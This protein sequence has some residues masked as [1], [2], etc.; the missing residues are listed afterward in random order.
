[1]RTVL[2]IFLG[3]GLGSVARYALG[4]LVSKYS[5]SQFPVG[6]LVV[7]IAACLIVGLL[8]GLIDQKAAARALLIVGFCGGF[9]TFSTFSVETID[10]IRG[11]FIGY[12]VF[13]ILGSLVCCI[14]ATFLGLWI[15]ART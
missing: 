6:T 10:L 15:A 14:G 11:G 13:Y 1:M 7:N 3:G 2:L 4:Q 9:S 8:A 12:V 5:H